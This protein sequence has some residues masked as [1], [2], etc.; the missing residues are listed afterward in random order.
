M[1]MHSH[2][3][4]PSIL[5]TCG[6][7]Y[8]VAYPIKRMYCVIFSLN[9]VNYVRISKQKFPVNYNQNT[10]AIATVGTSRAVR[11]SSTEVRV[12]VALED[13]RTN[14]KRASACSKDTVSSAQQ[15]TRIVH[16]S[17]TL[18]RALS[19][20][21]YPEKGTT[22]VCS[23]WRGTSSR[24]SRGSCL[25][26]AFMGQQRWALVLKTRPGFGPHRSRTPTPRGSRSHQVY[27][28]ESES[29]VSI[30]AV[31]ECVCVCVCVC[32]REWVSERPMYT[33]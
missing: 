31:C 27:Q 12:P 22:C 2:S 33:Y 18:S 13:W 7:R 32:E 16:R 26:A 3:I 6:L 25:A 4:L 8:V 17:A 30:L 29:H 14:L 9:V 10:S 20:F 19:G 5:Q 23:A 28:G 1:S 15:R 11:R 21:V 24:A